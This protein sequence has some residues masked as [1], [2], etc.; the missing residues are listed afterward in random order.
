MKGQ[1][2]F[3][4][5]LLLENRHQLV[6]GPNAEGLRKAQIAL[7]A[8]CRVT[9]IGHDPVP[10]VRRLARLKKIRFL[11]RSWRAS[12][13]ST[14]YSVIIS[15]LPADRD[16][17]KIAAL[18]G[19]RRIWVNILDRPPLCTFFAPAIYRSGLLTFSVF[20]NGLAPILLKRIR[21]DLQKRY[22]DVGVLTAV[23]GRMRREIKRRVPVESERRRIAH[24]L[25]TSDWIDRMT[26]LARRGHKTRIEADARKRLQ[27]LI[28]QTPVS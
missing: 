25:V 26:H 16:N 22:A 11:E 9:V 23:I 12:D 10:E 1:K 15:C 2:V 18:C 28:R 7:A 5:G 27:R 17:L 19:R 8:G 20:A 21:E 24:A 3:P 13:I 14:K 4:V 6:I